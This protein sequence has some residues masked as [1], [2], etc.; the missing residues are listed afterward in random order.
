MESLTLLSPAKLNLF[1][2]IT[3]KRDDGYHNLQ[4]VFRLLDW[5]DDIRFVV[6]D[7]QFEI[8]SDEL[9]PPPLGE[10]RWGNLEDGFESIASPVRLHCDIQLT[11][12]INDNLIIKSAYA[13]LN[14]FK[15]N[16]AKEQTGSLPQAL[17]NK[18]PIIDIHLDK[19]I[20]TGAGLG[21][22]SSNSATTLMA[23]NQLWQL[24]L[25]NKQLQE[26]AVTLGADV[27]I[28][29][30]AKDAIAEGIG[31]VFTPIELPKQRYLLLTPSTHIA[32]AELFAHPKLQRNIKKLPTTKI[33][34]N[35][36][37]FTNELN[38]PYHNVFQPVVC[39]LSDK[40]NQ[41]LAYLQQF[42]PITHN[43]A[44]MT[45]SGSC[46][47]LPI[48]LD[49]DEK[50]LDIWLEHAPCSAVVTSSLS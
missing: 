31:E 23:L 14:Y 21:G 45:G 37:D 46:V 43:T 3:G 41:A 26:I 2:H 20:P 12:N 22:G 36:A 44:R 19:H 8:N 13:L 16:F 5:G 11:D 42:E 30:L 28:F 18:L 47:F 4:T 39:D 25:S 10:A 1:L 49:M 7:K 29:I 15:K 38:A 34:E 40:V 6:T 33:I 27:P 32:T 50:L 24:G 48:A 35:S 9:I 17:P